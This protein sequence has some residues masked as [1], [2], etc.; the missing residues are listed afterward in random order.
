M[1]PSETG[2]RPG[3]EAEA[4][5]IAGLLDRFQREFDE[6]TPG[7]GPLA[8]RVRA[9]VASEASVFVL[10]G[11]RHVGV[12]QLRF[13]DHLFTADPVCLLEEFYVVPEY[14][15][16]GY[17]TA[18]LSGAIHLARRRGAATMELGTAQNDTAAR[19]LYEKYGFTNLE[20]AGHPETRMLYYEREI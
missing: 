10:A 4:D 13:R 19:N 6:Y 7:A 15:G 3:G 5:E 8:E 12:A 18:V 1:I 9:H 20:R 14:R 2:C 11:P 17:G 16:R